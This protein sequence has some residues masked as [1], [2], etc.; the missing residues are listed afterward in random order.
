MVIV[1][2]ELDIKRLFSNACNTSLEIKLRSHMICIS[3][4]VIQ[5]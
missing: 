2:L 1:N 5:K 4:I 3:E